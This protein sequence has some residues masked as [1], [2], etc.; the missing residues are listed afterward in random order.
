M[1]G[2]AVLWRLPDSVWPV[3]DMER[4]QGSWVPVEATVASAVLS[5]ERL[6]GTR[7]VFDGVQF[8]LRVPGV[9][10]LASGFESKASPAAQSHAIE[11]Q[12]P[13]PRSTAVYAFEGDWLRLAVS[14]SPD[15][16]PMRNFE[17]SNRLGHF[18]GTFVR[19]GTP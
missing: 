19:R 15:D 5:K 7:L 4:L 2:W 12:M 16:P 10:T 14:G 8:E 11:L 9:R 3:A 18:V 13:L 6:Q 1:P 17:P